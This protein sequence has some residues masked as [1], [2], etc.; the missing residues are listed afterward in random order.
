[1]ISV[2]L[3]SIMFEECFHF[4]RSIPLHKRVLLYEIV[5]I[6]LVAGVAATYSAITDLTVNKF[7]VPC[8]VSPH[9]ACPR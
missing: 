1:M 9:Q 3:Y 5:F 4:S 8:Y 6:G 7:T 2:K